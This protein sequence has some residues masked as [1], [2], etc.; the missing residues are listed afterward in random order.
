MSIYSE[1]EYILKQENIENLSDVMKLDIPQG[2]IYEKQYPWIKDICDLLKN[3]LVSENSKM[4]ES[5]D[6]EIII[7]DMIS[8]DNTELLKY[9]IFFP[10]KTILSAGD[11]LY[12]KVHSII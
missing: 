5:S 8:G 1:M 10:K 12:V 9:S 3:N 11:I 4:I 6:K 7:K 2:K